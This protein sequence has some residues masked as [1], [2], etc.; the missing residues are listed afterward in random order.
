M[1]LGEVGVDAGATAPL[2]TTEMLVFEI[3]GSSSSTLAEASGGA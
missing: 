2:G 3:K 1:R